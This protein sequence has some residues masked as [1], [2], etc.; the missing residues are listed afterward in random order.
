[1]TTQP[2]RHDEKYD[3]LLRSPFWKVQVVFD[4]DGGGA[5]FAYTIGLHDRGLPE[6]HVW[7]RPDRGED[8][9]ADW[10]LSTQDRCRLLNQLAARLVHGDLGVGSELSEKVDGGHTTI[11]M[12]VSPPGEPER[13][14]ALGVH[15]DAT[16]LPV[17]WSLH[18]PPE[19]P[20]LPL[21]AAV[22]R[23]VEPE[24]ARLRA[25]TDSSARAPR[26]WEP[27]EGGAAPDFAVDQPFGP[28]T[29]L[30]VARGAQLWQADDDTLVRAMDLAALLRRERLL[31]SE[32]ARALAVGRPIGRREPIERLH[33]AVQEAV[34]W[35]TERPQA[36]RRWRS[37][38]ASLLPDGTRRS[39]RDLRRIES[40]CAGLLHDLALATLSADALADVA[41][42]DV[43]LGCRGPWMEVFDGATGPEW[44][45][46]AG[47]QRA[48]RQLLEPLEHP[49]LLEIG[50]I[51]ANHRGRDVQGGYAALAGRLHAASV[52]A[53]AGCPWEGLL[54][55]LPGWAGALR[56][57][58]VR[59]VMPDVRLSVAV[60]QLPFL[61]HWASCLTA[62]MTQRGRFE[63]GELRVFARPVEGILPGLPAV[64][65]L[66]A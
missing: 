45:A 3:E 6:L 14:E 57:D 66:A 39:G 51:H 5:D 12:V 36:Q 19:G 48:V 47:V 32:G 34:W 25:V 62:A 1:M 38:V 56:L 53:A 18:R 61:Q 16:V 55:D 37:L 10:M 54:S 26:G 52:T 11:V 20:A 41:S 64:L 7:A 42:D 15:P 58:E 50:L 59:A 23:L 40:G 28:L 43:L 9:G 4:P 27:S 31:G 63:D 60:P 44:Q 49:T 29:P 30:V 46:P 65:G 35:L 13:L 24:V 17:R 33:E 22:R 21:T 8:P 2:L